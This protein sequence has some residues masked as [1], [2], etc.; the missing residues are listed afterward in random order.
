[1]NQKTTPGSARSPSY[2]YQDLLDAEQV[3]VPASLRESTEINP[4]ER[5]TYLT[6]T[7]APVADFELELEVRIL[8]GNSGVQ[9]RSREL[10][11]WQVAGYQADLD[12]ASQWTGG[13]YEQDGRG[14]IARGLGLR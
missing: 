10:G 9:F 3:D 7:E 13:V 14:V 6:W 8:G 12:A 5:T 2:S 11:E 1:M 4:L